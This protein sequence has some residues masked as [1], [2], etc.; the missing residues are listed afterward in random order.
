MSDI[1]KVISH[2]ADK[3]KRKI[4]IKEWG[5]TYYISPLTVSETRRLFQ[6]AR[7]DEV[8]M[9]VDAIILKAE[10]ENGEK[11]FSVSD[12]DK[13]M[14]EADIGIVKTVGSFIVNEINADDVKKN[15]G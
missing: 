10:K 3:K 12:K 15:F 11:A 4:E 8:T 1:D 7:K 2:F 14:N 9:L 5:V 13:L 6:S